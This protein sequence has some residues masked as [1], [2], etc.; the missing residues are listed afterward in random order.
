MNEQKHWQ[1]LSQQLRMWVN[2]GILEPGQADRILLEK[3]GFQEKQNLLTR[4]LISISALLFGLGII[5]FFAFNWADMPKWLKLATIFIGFIG[6]HLAGLFLGQ[7]RLKKNLAEFFHL[8][9][10][11]LFGAGI[12]LIAQ[13]YHINEH[14]PNGVLLWSLGAL[15]MAYILNSTP[16][17]LLFGVLAVVWQFMERSYD[18]PQLWAIFYVL[19]AMLPLTIYKKQWFIVSVTTTAACIV[20]CVQLTFFPMGIVGVFLSLGA[21]CLGTGVL[22]RRSSHVTCA[23]PVEVAG[24]ILYYIS[25]IV[26][27]FNGGIHQGLIRSWNNAGTTG[28]FIPVLLAAATVIVWGTFCFPVRTITR[29]FGEFPHKHVFFAFL[30]FLIGV[31]IWLAAKTI[32]KAGF[33]GDLIL[34]GMILFNVTAF[35]HGLFLIFSGTRSGRIGVSFLGCVLTIVVILFRF[36]DYSDDLLMRSAS[37]VCAGGF[38]LWIAILT[39]QKKKQLK[40]HA[41]I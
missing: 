37:F 16:Q 10:T 2:Q 41:E 28:I 1:W 8:L 36:A 20:I 15:V 38:V 27:T 32:F 34:T 40:T 39:S 6:V 24:S 31:M 12:M 11:L 19:G 18:I 30:G 29:R 23:V 17:M 21:L 7:N 3:P 25:L 4:I 22:I 14:T 13:I 26:L 33:R 5:S 35:V 9:G